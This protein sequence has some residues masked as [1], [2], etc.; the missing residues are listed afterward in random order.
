LKAEK[1]IKEGGVRPYILSRN[2]RRRKMRK[3]EKKKKKLFLWA[4]GLKRL[5]DME[6]EGAFP[7]CVAGRGKGRV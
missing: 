6:D 5:T 4:P 3:K 1:R 7:S 2:N